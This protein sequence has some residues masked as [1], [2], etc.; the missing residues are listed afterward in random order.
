[1]RHLFLV[2][3]VA[4][5][6][7]A[8]AQDGHAIQ[9]LVG[10]YELRVEGPQ[11]VLTNYGNQFL[12]KRF[13][14]E[15][16]RGVLQGFYAKNLDSRVRWNL[17]LSSWQVKDDGNVVIVWSTGYVG[18][19]IQLKP[20]GAGFRG[21]A[22]FFTDTGSDSRPIRVLMRPANCKDLRDKP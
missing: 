10:C 16:E 20:S 6:H 4:C 12:P 15:A 1:M 3:L 18:W 8:I 2:L 22:F 14:L 21:D 17:F 7:A 9:K 13:Q 19:N 11:R 5:A